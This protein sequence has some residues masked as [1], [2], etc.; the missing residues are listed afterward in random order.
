M[1]ECDAMLCFCG[2]IVKL[3][4]KY[5]NGTAIY[6]NKLLNFTLLS[7]MPQETHGEALPWAFLCARNDGKYGKVPCFISEAKS[8]VT[9]T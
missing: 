6:Y 1:L 7:G 4:P 9:T 8:S 2:V 5:I 3:L